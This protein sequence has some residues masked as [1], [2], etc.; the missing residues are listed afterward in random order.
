LREVL[1]ARSDHDFIAEAPPR[2]RAQAKAADESLSRRLLT[3]A[4]S[5]PVEI[6]VAAVLTAAASAIVWNALIL[7]TARHPAPLF[8][9]RDAPR[10]ERPTPLPP[11]RPA[12]EPIESVVPQAPAVEPAPLP[13]KPAGRYAI[14]DLIRTGTPPARPAPTPQMPAAPVLA[15]QPVRTAPPAVTV[16]TRPQVMR[17]AIGDLIR[18]GE[19]APVPPGLV[20]KPEPSRVVAQGQQALTK[21]GYGPLKA[22]GVMG[23]DTRQALERFERARRLPVTGELGPRT[24]RELAAQSGLP[25][26]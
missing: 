26:D 2:R 15:P 8:G 16:P 9:P 17:D 25:V 13:P 7:Q 22:D 19:P 6:A 18:L 10:G 4:A 12:I 23:P 1:A 11:A 21:L 20:G 14:G 3:F 5:H 24:A